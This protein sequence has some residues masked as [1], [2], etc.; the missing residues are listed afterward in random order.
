MCRAS[1]RRFNLLDCFVVRI[2]FA[3]ARLLAMTVLFKLYAVIASLQSRRSI[4]FI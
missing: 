2:R 4:K 3:M 1:A